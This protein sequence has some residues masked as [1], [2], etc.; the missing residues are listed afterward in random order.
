MKICSTIHIGFTI[1]HL[2]CYP[3]NNVC[4]FV[5]DKHILNVG[6]L[7]QTKLQKDAKQ[8]HISGHRTSIEYIYSNNFKSIRSTGS[9]DRRKTTRKLSHSGIIQFSKLISFL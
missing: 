4:L 9:G 6:C 1:T 5:I 7:F 2:L 3:L 8:K